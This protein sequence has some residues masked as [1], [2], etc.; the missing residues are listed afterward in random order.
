MIYQRDSSLACVTYTSTMDLDM[1]EYGKQTIVESNKGN[2]TEGGHPNND[3]ELRGGGVVCCILSKHRSE[4]CNR[5][6]LSC[7]HVEVFFFWK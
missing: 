4:V 7:S 3:I 6:I 5:R 2:E 1:N